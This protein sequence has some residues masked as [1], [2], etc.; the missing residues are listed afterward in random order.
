MT[1]RLYLAS[2]DG[3]VMCLHDR[4]YPAPLRMKTVSELQSTAVGGPAK[5]TADGTE[6]KEPQAPKDA[7]AA[8]KVIP[9]N[10]SGGAMPEK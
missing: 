3:L 4:D 1:D 2:N 9:K 7:G 10:P 5:K 6:V 8:P